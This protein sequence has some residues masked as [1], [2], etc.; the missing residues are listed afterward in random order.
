MFYVYPYIH[1]T[2]Q[3]KTSTIEA[4]LLS[5]ALDIMLA[6]GAAVCQW[7]KFKSR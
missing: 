1:L 4:I 3:G 7:G 6:F 5:R 2:R